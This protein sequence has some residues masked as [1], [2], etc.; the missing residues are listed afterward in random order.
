VQRFLSPSLCRSPFRSVRFPY[1]ALVAFFS[2]VP[3]F[4]MPAPLSPAPRLP[5]VKEFQEGVNELLALQGS[6]EWDTPEV[7]AQLAR[8]D[9]LLAKTHT[10]PASTSAA[11]VAAASAAPAPSRP[12]QLKVS[13]LSRLWRRLAG[14]RAAGVAAEANHR[15]H[16][17]A[18]PP[19]AVVPVRPPSPT[20]LHSRSSSLEAEED[21]GAD[22][23][24]EDG[25]RRRQVHRHER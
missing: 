23:Q 12:S 4:V 21:D 15:E 9:V 3:L 20:E 17:Q 25:V 7:K 5:T 10:R 16:A 11:S 1:P 13:C 22:G 6:P 24:A 14:G 8:L 19:R 18:E 2:S